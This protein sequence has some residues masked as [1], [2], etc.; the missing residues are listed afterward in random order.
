MRLVDKS[1]NR[2]CKRRDCHTC[3]TPRVFWHLWISQVPI[4][5]IL[6]SFRNF[7]FDFFFIYQWLSAFSVRH[8][9]QSRPQGVAVRSGICGN[10]VRQAWP[11]SGICGARYP[12]GPTLVTP[13]G[14]PASVARAPTEKRVQ[15][16]SSSCTRLCRSRL[17]VG[18]V[19]GAVGRK[20]SACRR[21]E[22][23]LKLY[24]SPQRPTRLGR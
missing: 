13:A 10:R 20:L 2:R 7:A 11:P 15:V 14:C 9:W 1:T 23:P 24:I 19:S 3:R 21:S 5:N 8:L 17:S 6:E 18:Q 4:F 22:K 16:Q 12:Q